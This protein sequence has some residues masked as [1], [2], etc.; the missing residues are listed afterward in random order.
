ML[1]QG[2]LECS[3][4]EFSLFMYLRQP[5]LGRRAAATCWWAPTALELA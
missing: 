4:E 2:P 3:G 5:C 1:A